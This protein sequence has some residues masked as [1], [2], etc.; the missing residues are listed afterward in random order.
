MEPLDD[1]A[2]AMSAATRT[3]SVS[4]IPSRRVWQ[5]VG[6]VVLL[7]LAFSQNGGLITPDTKLD[8]VIDPVGF[9]GR[10]LS[11]WDPQA[12]FG[13]V[14][15]QAYGY[16]WPMGPFFAAGHS[17]A[18]PDW[19][20]Q[21]L[22]W[23]LL[24]LVAYFGILRLLALWRVG[25]PTTRVIA[26]LAYALSPRV[27]S[28]IGT[29]SSEAWPLAV[30]PWILIPLVR[31]ARGGDPRRAAMWSGVAIACLGAVN[32]VATVMVLVPAVLFL[33]TR[34]RGVRRRALAGWWTL[35]AV[36]ACLW[37]LIPLAVQ[38]R[39]APPFLSTIESASVTTSPTSL[40][41]GLRGTAQWMAYVGGGSGAVW[42]AGGWLASN[43]WGIA[44]TA[45]VAA[46]GVGGLAARVGGERRFLALTALVG[47]VALAIGYS[48][49][50]GSPVA[51][52]AQHLLDGPLA[53][54]RNVHKADPLIRLPLVVGLAAALAALPR[55]LAP[56]AA[57]MLER[58]DPVRQSRYAHVLAGLLVVPV[59]ILAVAPALQGRLSPPGSMLAIPGQW[60]DAVEALA[61]DPEAMSGTT[62]LVPASNFG[63]YSWGRPLDEPM[64]ALAKSRWA[65]R[66]GIP[67][68]APGAT[69]WLDGI[70]ASLAQ[71]VRDDHL[72]DALRS[73]GVSRLL[74]RNDLDP[75]AGM[76]SAAAARATLL[77]SPGIHVIDGFG[78]GGSTAAG[79]PGVATG[80]DGLPAIE[81]FAVDGPSQDAEVITSLLHVSGGPE[82]TAAALAGVATVLGPDD[83]TAPLDVVT[84]TYRLRSQNFGAERG[85]DLTTTL[86]AGADFLRGRPA[87]DITAWDSSVARSQLSLPPAATASSSA[88]DPFGLI[89]RG[90]GSGP[91]AAA[92][93]DPA[94]AWVSQPDDGDPWWLQTFSTRPV[95]MVRI[96]VSRDTAL[97]TVNTVD[98]EAGGKAV[99]VPV[100]SDGVAPTDFGGI[101]S[102]HVRVTLHPESHEPVSLI[103]VEV[104]GVA[105]DTRTVLVPGTAP[106]ARLTASPGSRRDCLRTRGDLVTCARGSGIVGEDDAGWSRTLTLSAPAEL[107]GVTVALR[108]SVQAA[109]MIDRASGAEVTAP[110]SLLSDPL[111]RPA[112]ALDED[113]GTA[114]LTQ[115][116][117]L[118]PE[119]TV[120]YPEPVTV[121]GIAVVTDPLDRGRIRRA[122]VV[123]DG[124]PR[125]TILKG[126][127]PATFAPV[128][129]RSV[130]V[131]FTLKSAGAAARAPVR[132]RSIDLLGAP[133]LSSATVTVPCGEGPS[134]TMNGQQIPLSITAPSSDLLDGAP[135]PAVPCQQV[136]MN[137]ETTVTTK[138]T[139][140]WRVTSVDIGTVSAPAATA[141]ATTD[142][143]DES[144]RWTPGAGAAGRVLATTWG[145]NSG[146]RATADG[147][148]LTPV[149]VDG[150]RQGWVLPATTATTAVVA[151]FGPGIWHRVG[152][153]V[154]AVALLAL[155]ALALIRPRSRQWPA[156]APATGS[157]WGGPAIAVIVPVALGGVAG[158]AATALVGFVS[159][160]GLKPR[161]AALVG[162]VALTLSGLTVAVT[163]RTSWGVGVIPAVAQVLALFAV[164]AVGWLSARMSTGA[165]EHR[166]LDHAPT[167]LSD[168]KGD[169]K[170]ENGK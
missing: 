139:P 108:P 59:L 37:W 80:T 3:A 6:A 146:W 129:G 130:R 100:G 125:T 120:T 53:P 86:D 7:A 46:L 155:L 134:I 72:A 169:A 154:G 1:V 97:A 159:K 137:A 96:L 91:A 163:T 31:G 55:L 90:S 103:D 158:L 36:L 21:R 78:I 107:T 48:G 106:A 145:F 109:A 23:S 64:Q 157:R 30:L 58:P 29:I 88:A 98:V 162:A 45:A 57:R 74:L 32:A 123:V 160:W 92:D 93:A 149:R 76:P 95:G 152:L 35:A 42:D 17:V 170:P 144:A 101:A 69:R 11:A 18:V 16:L 51:G 39:V 44:A 61:A 38:S 147:Q 50:V 66:N 135:V 151:D 5:A 161:A 110:R 13:Q 164:A 4:A 27:L 63:S 81:L 105:P 73:A 114:W 156:V 85:S 117:D 19:V 121:R 167:H 89:Y 79:L 148:P 24:L 153:G 118:A 116:G 126:K 34:A 82:A 115:T 141:V 14:Q 75:S 94:T 43:A 165:S 10:A 112:A 136:T 33:L 99:E 102:D 47:L 142:R 127:L 119:L 84:D 22:W 111:A 138:S 56:V 60:T 70:Q 87:G 166:Q 15:N 28:V 54:L 9:L 133:R 20:T 150:W 8:L 2:P 65:I 71:G 41:N 143:S 40:L 83:S 67:L 168:D 140:V 26:A 25:T 52:F 122:T 12:A 124:V 132:V 131:I 113:L 49:A 128:T 68:G 104:A 62:L 77:A